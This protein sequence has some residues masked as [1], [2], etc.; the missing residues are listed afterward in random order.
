VKEA[1]SSAKGCLTGAT[2]ACGDWRDDANADH[3]PRLGTLRRGFQ[4]SHQTCVLRGAA[5]T[6]CATDCGGP[7][8]PRPRRC[9][10]RRDTQRRQEVPRLQRA[11]DEAAL[12]E[13]PSRSA[14][15]DGRAV[16]RTGLCGRAPG[17]TF[18]SSLSNARTKTPVPG[19]AGLRNEA[20]GRWNG[21]SH[22][23]SQLIGPSSAPF[24]S[25]SALSA[26]LSNEAVELLH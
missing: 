1:S 9:S 18:L 7:D 3:V 8:S 19:L 26:R 13:E 10:G 12:P 16:A 17:R 6:Q 5:L 4:G 14:P 15:F 22:R 23:C 11:V 21:D 20:R 2:K 25:A 24:Q